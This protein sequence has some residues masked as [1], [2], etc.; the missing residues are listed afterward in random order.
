MIAPSDKIYSKKIAG[1]DGDQYLI[2]RNIRNSDLLKKI[3]RKFMTSEQQ[4]RS[5]SVESEN[6]NF[7]IN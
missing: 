1:M 3:T 5:H 2:L 4:S 6:F 7:E